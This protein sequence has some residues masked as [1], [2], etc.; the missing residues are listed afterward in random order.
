M[1]LAVAHFLSLLFTALTLGAALAHLLALPNKIHLT[2]DQ[3]FTVQQIYNGWALLGIVIAGALVSTLVLS[4]KVRKQRKQFI[5][6]LVAFLCI[7]VSQIVFWTFTF[8]ANQATSNWTMI[9]D[10][11]EWLRARWEYSHATGAIL[12]L[13]AFVLLAL[14]VVSAAGLSGRRTG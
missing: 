10:N 14:S 4:I 1:G 11:W 3:Y 13:A 5:L 2:R 7:V 8:P 6:A 12:D 9:P